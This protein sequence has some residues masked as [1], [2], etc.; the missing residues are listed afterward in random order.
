M[1]S[2]P[3]LEPVSPPMAPPRDVVPVAPPRARPSV[4]LAILSF[5]FGWSWRLFAGSLLAL[6]LFT[7]LILLG[8]LNRWTQGQVVYFWWRRGRANKGETFADFSESLGLN[9]PVTRPR[10]FLRENWTAR[11]LTA[12]LWRRT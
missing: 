10:L 2:I 4:V 6:N 12:E 9:G 7:S 11:N 8:W 1:K 3:T 5:V